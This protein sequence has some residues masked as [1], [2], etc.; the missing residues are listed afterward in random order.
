MDYDLKR[1]NLFKKHLL[2]LEKLRAIYSKRGEH[3]KATEVHIAIK[4]LNPEAIKYMGTKWSFTVNK[5]NI[6]TLLPN[7]KVHETNKG[8]SIKKFWIVKDGKL[9]LWPSVKNGQEGVLFNV[10]NENTLQH[11]ESILKR[12]K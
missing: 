6:I 1:S 10:V 5:S 11:K 2:N 9:K 4:N 3:D 8:G 12:V 7:G